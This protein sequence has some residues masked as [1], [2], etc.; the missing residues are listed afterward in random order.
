MAN[1]LATEAEIR[2]LSPAL[3]AE[4]PG[5]P[6]PSALV[7]VW[8]RIAARFIGLAPWGEDASDGHALLTAHFLARAVAGAFGPA[9]PVTSETVDGETT[10]Y[11]SAMVAHQLGQT[12]YGQAYL[13]LRDVVLARVGTTLVLNANVDNGL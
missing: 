10:A 2:G 7:T 12:S 3:S 11:A 1:R 8:S 13:A 9:G 5:S 4:Y 6:Y